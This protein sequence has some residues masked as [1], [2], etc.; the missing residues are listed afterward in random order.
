MPDFEV[1]YGR[2]DE[3]EL[4]PF[5]PWIDMLRPRLARLPRGRAAP[6]SSRGAP[7]LARLL[8]ELRERLP[9]LGGLPAVR[10]PGDASAASCSA[11]SWRSCAGSPRHGPCCWSSTTCTGP[12]A[13][14]CC[15]PATS[16]ASRGSARCCWSARSATPSCT[17]GHPL[18]ELLAD[19]E[20]DRDAAAPAPRRHGRA[21][22]SRSWSAAARGAR[23]RRVV[24]RS[25]RRPAAT[26]SSSSSS[27]R[28]LE[29]VGVD[30]ARDR[31]RSACPRACAT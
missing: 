29:E 15:S 17:P 8:P 2:C 6:S 27:S 24:A 9:D 23:R 11:P 13:P 5:G 25:T 16:R 14:R 10:R 26:R 20:R 1:L 28:H 30:G 22:R 7:E 19:L 12:T 3:E 18:P 21:A 31:R 4:F